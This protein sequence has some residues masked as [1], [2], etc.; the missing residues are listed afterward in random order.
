MLRTEMV[1][2]PCRWLLRCWAKTGYKCGWHYQLMEAWGA[3]LAS[4]QPLP[5]R[6]P[7]SKVIECDLRDHVQR[8]IFFCGAY[9]PR[10]AFLFT[11]LAQPGWTVIDAGANIG[12]YTLLAAA[13]VG[14][15][16]QVHSFEPVPATYTQLRHHVERNGAAN[17]YV[18]N[19]AL[20]E[21]PAAL[22]LG[23]D[24]AAGDLN[25]GAYAVGAA[26]STSIACTAVRLT[27]YLA[28]KRVARVDLL[29][30]DIE[31]AEL[32]ALRGMADVL[33]RDHPLILLEANQPACHRLGYGLSDLWSFLCG[34][35]GYRAWVPG[36]TAANWREVTNPDGLTQEN[37]YFF[38]GSVPD[39]L[40]SGWTFRSTLRW[41]SQHL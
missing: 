30:M 16:G 1:R 23:R 31:G 3:W 12:Q 26:G 14:R 34:R 18:N 11:R 20:W 17:A 10:D 6:L 29:K 25:C 24:E 41:A 37:V 21:E 15:T 19:L 5:S 22:F 8:H 9:E 38:V 13:R 7:L 32:P 35:F 33:E 27:D 36:A 2:S 39:T 40:T 28:A 4:A